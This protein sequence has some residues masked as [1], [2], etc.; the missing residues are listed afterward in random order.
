M[1]LRLLDYWYFCKCYRSHCYRRIY[2]QHLLIKYYFYRISLYVLFVDWFTV[3]FYGAILTGVL[4]SCVDDTLIFC[5]FSYQILRSIL[6]DHRFICWY[7][8][9][10]PVI[11][12]ALLYTRFSSFLSSVSLK[13]FLEACGC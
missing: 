5:Q 13:V 4:I 11:F 9:F 3:L 6:K 10:F 12:T 8:L 1:A 2:H 7:L